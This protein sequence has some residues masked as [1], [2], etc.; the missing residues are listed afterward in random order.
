M[1]HTDDTGDIGYASQVLHDEWVSNLRNCVAGITQTWSAKERAESASQDTYQ[2]KLTI[3]SV[4]SGLAQRAVTKKGKGGRRGSV[5]AAA[6]AEFAGKPTA[7]A[8]QPARRLN[9]RLDASASPVAVGP[10]LDVTD[11]ASQ[12][13]AGAPAAQVDA[14]ELA[15]QC[16]VLTLDLGATY[17]VTQQVCGGTERRRKPV[18]ADGYRRSQAVADGCRRL[19]TV[20]DG[21]PTV[22]ET[23]DADGYRLRMPTAAATQFLFHRACI[24]PR[25]RASSLRARLDPQV[26]MR[27]VG[28]VLLLLTKPVAKLPTNFNSSSR[29]R[30]ASANIA[31]LTAFAQAELPTMGSWWRVSLRHGYRMLTLQSCV[32]LRNETDVT[33]AVSTQ[34][35]L[36]D[37][38]LELR[39][40]SSQPLPLELTTQGAL[41]AL[42]ALQLRPEGTRDIYSWASLS[43]WEKHP[44][45]MCLV[46]AVHH[47]SS[48]RARLPLAGCSS[49][50][51]RT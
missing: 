33:V 9:G 1:K 12:P 22:I 7:A 10:S 47:H 17:A 6:A 32:E 48:S 21:S 41:A 23:E 43:A 8:G 49:S 18:V 20:T 44:N 39:P 30:R 42:A 50:R 11:E 35:R 46:C 31:H 29:A 16:Y 27:N 36:D 4:V 3:G 37:P 19:P 5:A 28:D 34:A 13:Q 38:W 25:R 40:G 2:A 14:E 15:K 51:W 24:T 45:T 26:S